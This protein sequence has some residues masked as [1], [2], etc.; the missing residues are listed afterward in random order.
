MRKLGE[1]PDK[2]HLFEEKFNST[3]LRTDFS[4]E[5]SDVGNSLLANE[6]KLA[7]REGFEPPVRFP[8][9]L[10]SSFPLAV[11]PS[12]KPQEKASNS[13]K[14]RLLDLPAFAFFISLIGQKLAAFKR[15]PGCSDGQN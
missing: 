4:P 5:T 2:R 14:Q 7:E 15:A 6:K 9:H 10:I 11:T 3:K 1:F 12:N 13:E 8:V